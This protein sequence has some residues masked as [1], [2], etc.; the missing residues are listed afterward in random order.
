MTKIRIDRVHW[1][2]LAAALACA[3]GP[4]AGAGGKP[5][6][7]STPAP[8]YEPRPA[9]PGASKNARAWKTGEGQAYKRNWGIE[10]IGI[11]AAASGSMLS[12]RYRVV[13]PNKSKAILD[14]KSKAYVIDDASGARLAVPAMEN[15]GEL[16]QS[17]SPQPDRTYFIIFGNPGQLVKPGSRVTVV[18]GPMHVTGMIAE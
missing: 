13:D 8:V 5:E 14:A 12:F 3:G 6:L 15:I 16:R 7:M 9:A 4:A 17:G 10:I 11:R 18:V 1:A 2:A